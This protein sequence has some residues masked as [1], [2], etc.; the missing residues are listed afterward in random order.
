MVFIILIYNFSVKPWSL[1]SQ[2]LY[3][4][5]GHPPPSYS[6]YPCLSILSI[7]IDH[8]I[9]ILSIHPTYPGE[10]LFAP[11]R[12]Y[13]C[14][15]YRWQRRI[16]T[17]SAK[18]HSDVT[19]ASIIYSCLQ[20]PPRAQNLRQGIDVMKTSFKTRVSKMGLGSF[21]N[22]N[23]FVIKYYFFYLI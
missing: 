5:K 12:F 17:L 13:I 9:Y 23:I 4:K 22:I 6:S 19:A 15:T 20:I 7:P 18:L 3:Y 10:K 11:N 1:V 21:M 2:V 16:C 14:S 8:P